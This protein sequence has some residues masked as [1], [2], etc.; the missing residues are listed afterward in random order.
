[1]HARR[2][3]CLACRAC[4]ACPATLSQSCLPHNGSLSPPLTS[5]HLHLDATTHNTAAT[6]PPARVSLTSDGLWL[7]K[8]HSAVLGD[9]HPSC[10]QPRLHHSLAHAFHPY[11][12]MRLQLPTCTSMSPILCTRTAC[13]IP[14]PLRCARP[15]PVLQG[16]EARFNTLS[17]S[18]LQAI[19][20][21]PNSATQLTSH[22]P[23]QTISCS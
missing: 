7:L 20:K 4:V 13:S 18:P 6:P 14:R 10:N 15:Q 23:C 12:P 5:A 19:D 17:A 2:V 11:H 21:F 3:A 8:F 9:I 22:T 1:M 16:R